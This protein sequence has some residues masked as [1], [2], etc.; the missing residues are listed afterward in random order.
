MT[1][2][3][4]IKSSNWLS[5]TILNGAMSLL[6]KVDPTVGGLYNLE[7]GAEVGY[8]SISEKQGL[9]IFIQG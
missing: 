3:S 5:A 4:S 1:I 2:V 6:R 9:Q 8:P 7:Y